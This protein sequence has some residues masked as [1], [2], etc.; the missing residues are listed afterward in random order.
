VRPKP[1][2]FRA[3]EPEIDP[4]WLPDVRGEINGMPPEIAAIVA[5]RVMMHLYR[6][7]PKLAIDAI[8]DGWE[9]YR[10]ET[11]PLPTGPLLL[12]EPLSRVIQSEV[13]LN[14]LDEAGII[15]VGDLVGSSVAAVSAT[16]RYNGQI[17]KT[18]Q[19]RQELINRAQLQDDSERADEE[20]LDSFDENCEAALT[21]AA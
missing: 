11:A 4:D 9:S 10:N 15:T 14:S 20:L 19:I 21:G 2:T 3:D 6:G 13:I 5:R 18:L 8:N 16:S 1:R 7:D 17:A 12:Q